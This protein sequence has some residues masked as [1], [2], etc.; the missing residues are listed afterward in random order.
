MSKKQQRKY[1]RLAII[2]A[3][4]TVLLGV[5]TVSVVRGLMSG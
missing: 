2:G 3:V 1:R 4:L 5:G